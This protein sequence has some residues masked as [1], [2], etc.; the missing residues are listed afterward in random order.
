MVETDL[1]MIWDCYDK[2]ECDKIKEKLLD[3]P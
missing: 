1:V 2:A 3:T